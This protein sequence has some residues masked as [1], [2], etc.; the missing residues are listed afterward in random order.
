MNYRGD[1]A[2]GGRS[3]HAGEK[4]AAARGHA[5]NIE[6]REPPGTAD[7]EEKSDEP[8]ELDEV[9]RLGRLGGGHGA[10]APNIGEERRGDS[11]ADNVGERIKLLAEFAGGAHGAG[12][13]AVEGIE[14]NGDTDGA[15][16]VVEIRRRA[17]QG[18]E[19]GVITAE[20]I[21]DGENSGKD[22]NAAAMPLI[23]KRAARLV[24]VADRV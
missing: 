14:Q 6:A 12:D 19:N 20:E 10:H 15:R 2:S 23:A 5:L 4:T 13:A 17:F 11:E 24:F 22:V 21:R 18:G 3:G 16:G 1:H 8:A 7:H 9:K